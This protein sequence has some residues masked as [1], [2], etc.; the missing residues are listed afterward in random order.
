MGRVDR[1]SELRR[2]VLEHLDADFTISAL[3]AL[4]QAP[5]ENPPGNER[6]AAEAA[7]LILE[8]IGIAS[9]KLDV[10]PGRPDLV[11]V[12]KGSCGTPSLIFNGHIDTVPI[13]RREDW[14]V[15]PFGAEVRNGRV[16]GRGST[17]MKSGLAAMIAVA[18]ALRDS[19]T[20][21]AG[22]L[23]L[24]FAVGEENAGAG[25]THLLEKGYRADYGV[26]TEPTDL[27]IATAQRGVLWCRA[28]VLGKST[29]ASVAHVGVNA[30]TGAAKVIEGLEKIN[31]RLQSKTH[32]L[33]PSPSVVATMLAGGFKENVVPERCEITM[34]RR[35]IPGETLEDA[36]AEIDELLRQVQTQVSGMQYTVQKLSGMRPSETATDTTIAKV[37]R[38]NMERLAGT[39]LQPWGTPYTSDVNY[40]I[41]DGGVEAV[42]FG[43]GRV[44]EC[45]CIDESVEIDQVIKAAQVLAATAVDLLAAPS[46]SYQ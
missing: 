15:D 46:T 8:R 13:G 1:I 12:I 39:K 26:V 5:S 45:H 42:T 7:A 18:K 3:R 27:K 19:G 22:D 30:I 43:P 6:N 41:L 36:L 2:K 21:L 14:S 31:E 9:Q 10:Y 23:L 16:Y 17:D 40:L 33:V 25:T 11:A 29:H 38:A 32:S 20:T 28:T 4:V 35:L 37:M 24:Q 44:E 34:D